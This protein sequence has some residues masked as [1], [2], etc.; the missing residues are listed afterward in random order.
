M[1][2]INFKSPLSKLRLMEIQ[3]LLRL[4]VMS[5]N[6]IAIEMGLTQQIVQP[7]I[8]YLRDEEYIKVE[9]EEY[10][11]YGRCRYFYKWGEKELE[12][13]EP[14]NVQIASPRKEKPAKRDQLV[15]ALFGAA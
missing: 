10:A 5:I 11:G 3:R 9:R 6:Q 15:A 4:D 1:A 12:F 14:V 8:A 13:R 7:Y 2:H